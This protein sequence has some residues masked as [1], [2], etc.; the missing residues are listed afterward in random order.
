VTDSAILIEPLQRWRRAAG[1]RMLWRGAG[2]SWSITDG[3]TYWEP[4]NARWLPIDEVRLS[5]IDAALWA[6]CC[7]RE[8][9]NSEAFMAGYQRDRVEASVTVLVDRLQSDGDPLGTW[10]ALRLAGEDPPLVDVA[11]EL[12]RVGE[13]IDVTITGEHI[14]RVLDAAA[15][16]PSA[17]CPEATRFADRLVANVDRIGSSNR[18][19]R[20]DRNRWA[21]GSRFSAGVSQL[22]TLRSP[23][24]AHTSYYELTAELVPI[25]DVFTVGSLT[26]R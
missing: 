8:T 4:V 1:S 20:V 9:A 11:V 5:T 26:T 14:R 18:G 10:L 15:A 16:E 13:A 24:V 2:D 17:W 21:F 6:L 3:R 7:A 12:I 22:I 23:D 25:G 19:V